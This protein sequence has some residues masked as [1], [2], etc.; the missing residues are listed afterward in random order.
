MM[1][2]F[3]K[4]LL[5]FIVICFGPFFILLLGG[6][7]YFDPF[8]VLYKYSDTEFN[9]VQKVVFPYNRDYMA[10]ELFLKN[11][12][13][14]KYNSFIFCS[15]RSGATKTSEWRKYLNKDAVP[16]SYNAAGESVYGIYKK[17]LFLDSLHV[18]FDNV[19][20]IL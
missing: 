16:F 17:L 11:Y 4:K 7:L 5:G 9:Q 12:P 14:Y 19:L 2:P 13:A 6:Y 18:K 3:L 8:K 10:T 15:S 20:I 1:K